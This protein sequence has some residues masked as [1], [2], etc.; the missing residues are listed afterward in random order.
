MLTVEYKKL[1]DD[2]VDTYRYTATRRD[3]L[4]L[5]L[6]GLESNRTNFNS[7]Y[8]DYYYLASHTTQQIS[9]ESLLNSVL[10]HSFPITISNGY[11]FDE[12]FLYNKT[13][14]WS[15]RNVLYTKAENKPK[16]YLRSLA[17]YE[18]SQI[19]FIIY[20]NSAEPNLAELKNQIDALILKYKGAGKTYK[21]EEYT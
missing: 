17:E 10:T 19:D 14:N 9:I 12:F 20:V 5:I 6:K 4:Y 16:T 8:N 1:A 21:I 11:W 2:I 15:N 18:S 13:E 7:A 3:W